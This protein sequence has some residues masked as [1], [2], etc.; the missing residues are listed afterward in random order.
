MKK[1]LVRSC[2]DLSKNFETIDVIKNNYIW[3][4]SGNMLFFYSTFKML[5]VPGVELVP[6]S[7]ISKKDAKFINK[8]YDVFVIPLANAFRISFKKELTILTK[9]IKKIKI[10]CIVLGV[11]LQ[12]RP[13]PDPHAK[14]S[15]DRVV[16]SFCKEVLKKSHS[17]GVRGNFTKNYLINLGFE[18]DKIQ[19]I[20]CPSMYING[21]NLKI[22][23][24]PVLNKDSIIC[25][26]GSISINPVAS[27]IM[28]K[29]SKNYPNSYYIS[30]T[31]Q[32]FELIY[33]GIP[34]PKAPANYLVKS[35][36]DY[37]YLENRV[38][39][40]KNIKSWFEFLNKAD[41]SIGGRIHGNIAAILSGTPTFIIASDS[42]VQE[43]ADLHGIPY[44]LA[45]D[46]KD[47]INI[48]QLYKELDYS[49]LE[50]L[51]HK[52]FDN[53][54]KFLNDNNLEHIYNY[55]GISEFDKK[56]ENV[57]FDGPIEPLFSIDKK[58]AAKRLYLYHTTKKK[59][60][61]SALMEKNFIVKKI[62]LFLKKY[63]KDI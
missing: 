47:D 63:I 31:I 29:I 9:L 33:A 38:R 37:L 17:I 20:G 46:L 2:C 58:E 39:C 41:F 10:P 42:R 62:V 23:K 26:N 61:L 60:S 25:M 54:L 56:L 6:Y 12:T 11:G 50:S 51:Q 15:F 22:S 30:Q 8:N 44:A 4:N 21:R 45:S 28:E 43:L 16:K 34:L 40:F 59:T 18:D 57:E 32:D 24:K 27:S 49:K 53:F 5:S 48:Q 3:N 19:V 7:K 14:Y 35:P 36:T 55:D 13:N 52:N 1:I